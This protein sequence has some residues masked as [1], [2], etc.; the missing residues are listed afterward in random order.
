MRNSWLIA[1]RELKERIGARSFLLFSI[2]GPLLILV[3]AYLLFAFGGEGKQRWNVLI[4]DPTG[5]MDAK[6]LANEDNSITYSFANDYIELEEFRDAKQFQPFDA[7]IEINEK[8]LSNK[9]AFIFF[10]EKPSVR[11]QTRLQFHIERRLEEV[12]VAEF[13]NLSVSAFRKIK[14][15]LNIAFRNAYDPLDEAS[16]L[17]GWVGFFF[18]AVIFLFI[19]LFGM[20]ILRSVTLEKSNRIIEVLLASVR[21]NQLMAGK[22]IGIGIAAF[23]QFAI[24]IVVIGFG[25][26]FLRETLFPDLL[27]AANMNVAQMTEEV[28]QQTNEYFFA[29]KEYNE[30]VDLVYERVQFGTMTAYFLLF[31]VVGYLFYGAFFAAIGATSG[32]ESDGQQFILP[33]IFILCFALYAGYFALENPE[34]SLVTFFHYLP[35]TSPVVV[36]V[37]LSQGY[38]PGQGYQLFLSLFI[39]LISSI[40]VL[41]IAGRLYKNGI[42]QYG[43]RIKLS[44]MWKW[45]KKM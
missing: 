7:M 12:L 4:S 45:L 24:W 13:T 29:T 44:L 6:I 11:M 5:I 17:R 2:F 34:S 14:Q 39:L 9:T 16:D 3:G 28:K 41:L 21:P 31:F 18:G 38:A 40:F 1:R 37:K 33:I 26:Y 27:D 36:M 19:F 42:L 10:R 22:I 35:F 15:P 43:H 30:F 8:V 20:T 23:I 25:L 32:S